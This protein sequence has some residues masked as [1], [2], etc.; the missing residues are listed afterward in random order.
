VRKKKPTRSQPFKILKY[1]LISLVVVDG[2]RL[3]GKEEEVD[4]FDRIL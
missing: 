2:G 3:N 4:I 1:V